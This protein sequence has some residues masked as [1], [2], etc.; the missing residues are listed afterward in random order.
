MSREYW[1]ELWSGV[2]CAHYCWLLFYAAA[3]YAAILSEEY[4]GFRHFGYD[5]T[6]FGTYRLA[7]S[8]LR[9]S[10][11]V[12]EKFVPGSGQDVRRNATAP[13]AYAT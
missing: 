1:F 3:I 12:R 10:A 13:H 6:S 5:N 4:S 9:R 7:V 11:D 8:I 2:S